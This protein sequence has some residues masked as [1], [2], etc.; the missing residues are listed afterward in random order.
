[1]ASGDLVGIIYRE[2]PTG[3]VSA[4]PG[5]RVGGSTP[6]ERLTHRIFDAATIWYMDYLCVLNGYDGGGITVKGDWSAATAT[7]NTTRWGA[8]FR[9]IEDDN[10]D[11][12]TSQTYDFNDVDDT[13]ASASGE[14]SRFSITFTNGADMDNVADGEVFILRVYRNATHANDNMTGNAELWNILIYET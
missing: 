6:T 12:D 11:I 10:E 9:R 13:C 1:M 5:V 8:A 2:M 3:T 4:P 7:S 14:R